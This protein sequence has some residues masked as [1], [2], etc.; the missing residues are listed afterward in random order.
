M[1]NNF[2]ELKRLFDEQVQILEK[3]TYNTRDVKAYLF[4]KLLEGYTIREAT[5]TFLRASSLV[6]KT[7]LVK[8]IP[9]DQVE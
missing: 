9:P 5:Q 6:G 8:P 2:N 7:T 4:I 3:E 1:E